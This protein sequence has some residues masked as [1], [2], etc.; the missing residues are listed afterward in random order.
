MSP[1]LNWLNEE[2]AQL[3]GRVEFDDTDAMLGEFKPA[4]GQH[5]RIMLDQ[6]Y[7]GSA[8]MAVLLAWWRAARAVSASLTFESPSYELMQ[9]I[10]VS[11]LDDI[12]PLASSSS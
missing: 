5:Y 7:G 2:Q 10:Q 12:M 11:D 3:V 4:S 6:A 8:A 1:S 9:F